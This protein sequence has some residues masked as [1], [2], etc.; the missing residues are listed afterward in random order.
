MIDGVLQVLVGGLLALGG[1]FVGPFFQ[2]RHERWIADREDRAVLRNKA[3]ELFDEL[4]SFVLKSQGASIAALARMQDSGVEAKPVPD[5]GRVRAIAAIY[6]PTSLT[7][8]DA[9]EA[10]NLEALRSIAEQTEEALKAGEKGLATLRGMPMKMAIEHQ[11]AAA[12]FVA[13]LRKHL[14]ENVPTLQLEKI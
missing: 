12:S 10:T 7:M 13:E 9:Y 8:I 5:L 14:S 4:D 11:Q 1:A 6:F 2:R 3:E